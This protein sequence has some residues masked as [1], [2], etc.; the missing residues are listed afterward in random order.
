LLATHPHARKRCET[1]DPDIPQLRP[2]LRS[3]VLESV[4]LWPT[5]PALLRE[6]VADTTWRDGAQRFTLSAG[7]TLFICVPAF[8]RDP[9]ALPFANQFTPEIWLDGRAECHP[10][11]VPFSAGPAQCPGQNLVLFVTSSMLAKLLDLLD[12]ELQS[13]PRLSPGTPLPVTLNQ[14]GLT[15]SVA[16]NTVSTHT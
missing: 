10:Q 3:C 14:F 8:H 11:L 12:T 4:R 9:D 13:H 16:P 1:A 15:F 5:T 6:T 7:A 2:Y